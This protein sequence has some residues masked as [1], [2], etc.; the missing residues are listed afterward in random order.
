MCALLQE[1]VYGYWEGILFKE[2]KQFCREMSKRQDQ[3]LHLG[4]QWAVTV[5]PPGDGLFACVGRLELSFSY[6]HGPSG[7]VSSC[8]LHSLDHISQLLQQCLKCLTMKNL[9]SSCLLPLCLYPWILFSLQKPLADYPIS[10][11]R[12]E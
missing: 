2:E 12:L 4:H 8:G 7:T 3:K 6:L 11:P 10:L 9:F 1:L 5:P